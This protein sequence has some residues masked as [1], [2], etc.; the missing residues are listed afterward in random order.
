MRSLDI[1]QTADQIIKFISQT[2]A[3]AG[4]R[5]VIVAVSGGVDSACAVSLATRALGAENVFALLLPYK[6]MQNEATARAKRL[7]NQLEFP[8]ARVK[9]INV[10]PIVDAAIRR[11]DLKF[12]TEEGKIRV[13]NI[14][15][16]TRMIV[17]FDQ[18]KKHNAL[19]LGTENKSEYLLGY[20]TRFGDEAS[21]LEPLRQ[22][23][24]TEIFKLAEFLEVPR[25]IINQ[26][27]TAGL[28]AGQTD[29]GEFGFTYKEADEILWGFYEA[30]L[31]ETEMVEQGVKLETLERVKNWVEKTNF[32]HHL[33][34]IAPKS[35]I[36]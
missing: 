1:P 30:K 31:T 20:F 7:L 25:E 23:Y 15:A 16:R 27:P 29:E 8:P 9:E 5:Q 32:K 33:P 19:V 34:Q 24:K 4:F 35:I 13:G 10:G 18:A 22:L 11:L 36:S 2:V 26:P 28:W 3:Q 12:P 21:D 17:L 14:M 6:N